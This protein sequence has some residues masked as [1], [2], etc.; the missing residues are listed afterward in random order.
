MGTLN[1]LKY[2]HKTTTCRSNIKGAAQKKFVSRLITSKSLH[3]YNKTALLP[4]PP[5]GP[6]S[7]RPARAEGCPRIQKT[8]LANQSLF[9]GY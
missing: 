6:G 8:G 9:F 4:N 3:E 7:G 5:P 2:S 1:E